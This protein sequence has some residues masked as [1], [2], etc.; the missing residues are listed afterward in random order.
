MVFLTM[1][2]EGNEHTKEPA[3]DKNVDW[4]PVYRLQ[5]FSDLSAR[6]KD[7]E[8]NDAS[9][10]HDGSNIAGSVSSRHTRPPSEDETV[11]EHSV[12]G[13]N[14]ETTTIKPA[15]PQ[16]ERPLS[17]EELSDTVQTPSTGTSSPVDLKHPNSLATSVEHLSCEHIIAEGESHIPNDRSGPSE[18]DLL[19][20]FSLW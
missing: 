11:L 18:M 2:S 3:Y 15:L 8:T 14:A 6:T 12:A 17:E 1:S 16:K 9:S 19:G 4:P 5:P 13:G 7:P 10:R 20:E